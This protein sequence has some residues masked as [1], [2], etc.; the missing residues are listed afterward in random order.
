MARIK[1]YDANSA[2]WKYA[3]TTGGGT[4]SSD[5]LSATE[6]N[7]ILTLFENAA[8]IN[9]DMG[10]TLQELMD[11]WSDGTEEPSIPENALAYWDYTMGDIRDHDGFSV[12]VPSPA[13]ASFTMEEEGMRIVNNSVEGYAGFT[14][15]DTFDFN[16][17]EVTYV[18]HP[19]EIMQPANLWCGIA[20]SIG[21]RNALT[22]STGHGATVTGT[23]VSDYTLPS[24]GVDYTIRVRDGSVY[25]NDTLVYAADPTEIKSAYIGLN[26]TMYLKS[27][28]V[29]PLEE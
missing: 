7:L 10:G 4:S 1:Y 3:D 26:G 5:C 8:Y 17:V 6:K 25:V 29:V 21:G 19:I 2:S 12:N 23:V 14:T 28:S 13:G 22:L 16:T 9:P 24:L 11:L 18:I 20:F 27:I 15:D